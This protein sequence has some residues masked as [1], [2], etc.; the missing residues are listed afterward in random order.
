M[1]LAVAEATSFQPEITGPATLDATRKASISSTVQARLLYLAVEENDSVRKG[2]LLARL[3]DA[4]VTAQLASQEA[5]FEASRQA[6]VMAKADLKQAFVSLTNAKTEFGRQTQLLETKTTSRSSY[7]TAQTALA[8]AEADKDKAE[9]NI[10][11]SQSQMTASA[12]SAEAQKALLAKYQIHAPLSGIVVDRTKDIGDALT[13]G[14]SFIEIVDPD[15]IVV[16]TRFD[17][18]LITSVGAGQSALVTFSADPGDPVSAEVTRVGR[19]VDEETREFEVDVKP[20][21]LP[22]HWAIGQRAN[23]VLKLSAKAS[24]ITIPTTALHRIEGKPGV[25]LSDDGRARWQP[26]TV[27]AAA[28]NR[29]EVLSGLTA[30]D[31]YAIA[32][33]RLYRGMRIKARSGLSGSKESS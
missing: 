5:S 28:G 2:D 1:A 21:R 10:Q 19:L 15:S 32:P 11:Q 17:E 20:D 6:V 7:E 9:A 23:V 27:G 16:T 3:D 25:W 33:T 26:V 30:G 14:S 29:I 8:R 12:K 22:T 18:S 31:I 4:E 24:T 13:V